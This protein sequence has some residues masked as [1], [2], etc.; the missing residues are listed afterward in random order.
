M[1]YLKRLDWFLNLSIFFL[2]GAGLLSL[3]STAPRLFLSQLLWGVIGL[4]VMIWVANFD[5]RSFVN[6][7]WFIFGIYG[8]SI[9]LLL[10]TYL[11]APPIRGVRAWLPIGPLQFQTSEIVKFALILLYSSFFAKGHIKIAHLRSIFLSFIYFL[12]PALLVV[13][14]PDMGSAL[15]I[16]SI[17]FGYL[18]VSG[19]KWKHIFLAA[20]VFSLSLVIMWTSVLREYQKDRIIGLFN[21]ERDPLGVNY[22]VIQ[23][24]IAIGSA[25]FWGKGFG[26]GTQ[27]QL[28]FLPE[29]QT[30][31]I[32][33]AFIEEWGMF[34]G[35]AII[36]GFLLVLL[37]IIRI[38]LGADDNFGRLI[39]LGASILFLSHFV[40]NV[41]SNLGLMPVVGVPFPFLSYG[42]S[43]LLVSSLLIGMIQGVVLYRRF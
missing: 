12:I 9:F 25:G 15:I 26:Q 42:G 4:G 19:L 2:F 34:G 33:S 31:F 35:I 8:L 24:K 13:V 7:R 14:Q 20:I 22:S 21:P 1:D 10:I 41:G 36:I 5:W 11:I 30:D 16:F 40:L 6:Y 37:R 3:A 43:N 32:F 18:L 23:A 28:G 29:A 27:A 17:W 38:G 39:C